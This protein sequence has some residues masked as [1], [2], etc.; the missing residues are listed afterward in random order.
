MEKLDLIGLTF[1]YID[2]VFGVYLAWFTLSVH[3]HSIMVVPHV[4]QKAATGRRG[5]DGITL[6]ISLKYAYARSVVCA[7]LSFRVSIFVSEFHEYPFKNS[8]AIEQGVFLL[9]FA[10]L[11]SK[12]HT[13]HIGPVR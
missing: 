7:A 13:Y 12:T 5:Q 6:S 11:L 10:D 4:S 2:T 8:T 9:T 3:K 1:N